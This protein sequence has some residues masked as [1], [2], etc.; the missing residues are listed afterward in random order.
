ME[1][2]MSADLTNINPTTLDGDS[3]Y[4]YN[5]HLPIP[6]NTY[7]LQETGIDL[8]LST[9]DSV[10]ANATLRFLTKTAMNAIKTNLTAVARINIEYLVAKSA[11]HRAAFLDV[12]AYLILAVKGNG[13]EELLKEGDT[14]ITALNRLAQLQAQANDLLVQRYDFVVDNPRSDY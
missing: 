12:V 6:T 4:D 5:L 3:V 11:R 14:K 1:A 2:N 8:I 13:I 9:G 7:I 10:Q